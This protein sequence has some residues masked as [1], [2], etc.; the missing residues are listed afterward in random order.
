MYFGSIPLNSGPIPAGMGQFLQNP[1]ESR[2]FQCH[3][4][5]FQFYSGGIRRNGCIP[6][7][8]CGAS[9]STAMEPSSST[10]VRS[11]SM[12]SSLAFEVL[13]KLSMS[14]SRCFTTKFFIRNEWT[15]WCLHWDPMWTV[16]KVESCLPW[17][18]E[19]CLMILVRW[20]AVHWEGGRLFTGKVEG[21]S[22]CSNFY[23]GKVEGSSPC[24]WNCL[25]T[26]KGRRLIHHI[27]KKSHALR[28]KNLRH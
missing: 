12:S 2:L 28:R 4:S 18:T 10:V 27:W 19:K 26:W 15:T 23:I 8:I 3:S 13:P 21:C 14:S 5:V 11:A 16:E 20:K 24:N 6:A 1:V 7:G 25:M 22:L 9:K 17:L